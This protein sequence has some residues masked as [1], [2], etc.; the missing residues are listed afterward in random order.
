MTIA[1]SAKQI[2]KAINCDKLDLARGE[3][4]WYFVYDDTSKKLYETHSVYCCYL[5]QM[6]VDQ[7]VE[8]GKDFVAK[9]QEEKEP[10]QPQ[11][12]KFKSTDNLK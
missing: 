12:L 9:M 7:W 10:F 6:T 2:L 5:N 3:G 11:S 1:K 8:E 4:Y